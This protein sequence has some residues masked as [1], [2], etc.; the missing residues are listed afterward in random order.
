MR[1]HLNIT[2]FENLV[3]DWARRA[4]N[5]RRGSTRIALLE[6]TRGGASLSQDFKD[7]K[8]H[9]RRPRLNV[10]EMLTRVI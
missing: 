9:C 3:L 6:H 2:H 4:K 8:A 5:S 7:I 10:F 1:R